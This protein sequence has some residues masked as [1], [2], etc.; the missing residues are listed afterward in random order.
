MIFV[1]LIF[2]N[3]GCI[4]YCPFSN[5]VGVHD[6]Y[7]DGNTPASKNLPQASDLCSIYDCR[8]T[9]CPDGAIRVFSQ[10]ARIP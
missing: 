2:V 10:S 9:H 4:G 6:V 7:V 8:L 5:L 3:T 1:N